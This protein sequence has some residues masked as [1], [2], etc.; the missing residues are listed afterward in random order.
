MA[1]SIGLIDESY[2]GDKDEWKFAVLKKSFFAKTHTIYGRAERADFV[3][4]SNAC[5]ISSYMIL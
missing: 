1:N 5:I 2:K 3:T 4:I